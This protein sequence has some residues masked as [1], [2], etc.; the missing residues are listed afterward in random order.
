MEYDDE[1][2]D[3]MNKILI[4]SGLFSFCLLTILWMP[5]LTA[6]QMPLVKKGGAAEGYIAHKDGLKVFFDALSDRLGIPIIVSK[7]VARK[8]ISGEFDLSEPHALLE[9]ISRQMGLVWYHDG[10]AIYIYDAA[11]MQNSMMSLQNISFMTLKNYLRKSSLYDERYPLRGDENRGTFYISGPPVYVDLVLNSARF[12]DEKVDRAQGGEITRVI[13]LNNTFVSDRSYA[14]RG[15]KLIIPG[16]ANVIG[17]LLSGDLQAVRPKVESG[18]DA[19]A[20]S[21]SD[22]A[23]DDTGGNAFAAPVQ[24]LE[25]ATE[26]VRVIANPSTNSLLVKGTGRQVELVRNLAMA[27]DLP[28]RHVE[29]SLWIVDMQK[30]DLDQLGINWQ[31]NAGIGNSLNISLNGGSYTTL[32]GARFMAS[33]MA[34]SRKNRANIVS[35]PIVLTQ[36]NVPAIFDNNRTFYTKLIGERS[37]ELKQ[38][39]Y[40]TL[41]SVL[42]RFSPRNEIEMVL[43]I[44]DGSEIP[45]VNEND[46]EYLPKVGRTTISTVARV[47]R[48]KSLLIGGYTR[49]EDSGN[50][51]KIPLLGDIPFIGGLFRYRVNHQS[52]T[53]RIFLIQPREITEPLA[54]DA[55]E[56]VKKIV[57]ER[58]PDVLQDWARNYLDSQKWQP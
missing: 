37:V 12:L 36:E 41:V 58:Q 3:K 2:I 18:P 40:G 46:D 50:T 19:A 13:Q 17:Q 26:S 21:G 39:T 27:L 56:F 31:G 11:E 29:L 25:G 5:A 7:T 32:N 10:Q 28:K 38:V 24:R 42:P 53:V 1:E 35:R 52:N 57:A 43:N 20:L 30:D 14:L 54:T 33:I 16:I 48:G 47:P 23:A 9:K 45:T 44:E 51:A 8:Q 4:R 55:S 15:E 49:D 34:L 22:V 6:T